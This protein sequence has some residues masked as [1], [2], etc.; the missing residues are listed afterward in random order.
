MGERR[1]GRGERRRRERMIFTC[2]RRGSLRGGT[3]DGVRPFS[4]CEC[5]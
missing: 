3:D 4:E 2:D 1:G 5:I